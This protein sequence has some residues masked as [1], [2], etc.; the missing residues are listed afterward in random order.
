MDV[1]GETEKEEAPTIADLGNGVESVEQLTSQMNELGVSLNDTVITPSSESMEGSN[2]GNPVQEIDKR[3]RA[4]KKKV[5]FMHL[6]FHSSRKTFYLFLFIELDIV[7]ESIQL[8][9]PVFC[10]KVARSSNT[11]ALGNSV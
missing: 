5:R 4:L 9:F 2:S 10:Q 8:S 3:I 11:L 6:A 7:G 1:T